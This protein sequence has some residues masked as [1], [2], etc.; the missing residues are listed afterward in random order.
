MLQMFVFICVILLVAGRG[1]NLLL[2]ILY[3]ESGKIQSVNPY[4][5]VFRSTPVKFSSFLCLFRTETHFRSFQLYDK[6]ILHI[7]WYQFHAF[8][9]WTSCQT[10]RWLLKP[11]AYTAWCTRL[12]ALVRNSLYVLYTL[13]SVFSTLISASLSLVTCWKH[14]LTA[15]QLLPV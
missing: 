7:F 4:N 1:I 9:Q 3:R 11:S 8:S 15:S 12:R 5:Q 6:C 10:E 2:P 13:I 14:L